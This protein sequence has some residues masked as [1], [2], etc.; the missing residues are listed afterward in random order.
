M[1]TMSFEQQIATLER[2]LTSTRRVLHAALFVGGVLVVG[3]WA[4]PKHQSTEVLR[5]RGLIVEDELGRE[6]IFIGAPVPDGK[7]GRRS[8]PSVGVVINDTAGYE[9]FGLGLKASGSMSMGFDAPPGAG[10][11][12]NRERINVIAD[13][14]G[15]ATIRMLDGATWVRARLTVTPAA[16]PGVQDSVALEFLD[17]PPGAVISRRVSLHGDTITRTRRQ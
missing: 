6:R 2:Q 7:D 17:F 8:S 16:R 4:M 10:D 11:D 13:A 1:M 9:R 14:R 12:R 3:A 15:G 5:V